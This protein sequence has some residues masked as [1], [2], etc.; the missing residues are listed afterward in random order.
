VDL[1]ATGAAGPRCEREYLMRATAQQEHAMKAKNGGIGMTDA[2]VEAFVDRYVRRIEPSEGIGSEC[3]TA[4]HPRT[5]FGILPIAQQIL[6]TPGSTTDSL[7]PS[8]ST[9]RSSGHDQKEQ[10][11]GP[12]AL[13]GRDPPGITMYARD[14]QTRCPSR[15]CAT[16]GRMV[17]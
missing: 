2:Q 14:G 9:A 17:G 10:L 16:K 1:A 5:S 15:S 11:N 13:A 4:M 3:R 7:S 8:I 12:S 6:D